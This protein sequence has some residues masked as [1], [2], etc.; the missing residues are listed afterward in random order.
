MILRSFL[1]QPRSLHWIAYHSKTLWLFTLS[2]HKTFILPETLFGIFSA[3]SD[4]PHAGN[5]AADHLLCVL[6]R[7]PL[8]VV[9]T[10]LNTFVFT[11]SN[12]GSEAAVVEDAVNKPWRPLPAGRISVDQT[13]RL[14]LFTVP[15]ALL[16]TYA[17]LG[18]AYETVLLACLTWLYNDL[19]GADE[20]F[21]VRNLIIAAAYACYGSGAFRVARNVE[22]HNV[23]FELRAWLGVISGVVFTTMSIQDLKDKQGDAARGRQT[24]PLQIGVCEIQKTRFANS[25]NRKC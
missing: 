6:R 1:Q 25:P 2:D 13:R 16:L 7:L 15:V 24:A 10:W 4:G 5:S 18:A 3:L 21:V 12:Q 17:G 22:L 14:L 9:W 19:R 8:V 23:P 11:L 20:S